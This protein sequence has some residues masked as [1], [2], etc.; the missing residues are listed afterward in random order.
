MNKY[1]KIN[2]KLLALLLLIF[3]GAITALNLVAPDR[4]LSESENRMLEQPPHFSLKALV[5]GDFT[6]DF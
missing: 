2:R 4:T 6:L 1:D 5:S 3:I